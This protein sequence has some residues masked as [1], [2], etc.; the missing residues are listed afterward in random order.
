MKRLSFIICQLSF[1]VAL[2]AFA[3]C[4]SSDDSIAEEPTPAQPA[5]GKYTL[6]VNAS[7]GDN[8][9]TRALKTGT[10]GLDGY[11]SAKRYMSIQHK[12]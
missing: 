10:D 12:K 1:S 5:N 3:A 7:K 4:S 2:V 8:A 11:W 6:T 9:M